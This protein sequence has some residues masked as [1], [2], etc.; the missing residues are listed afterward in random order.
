M[1]FPINEKK[2][3]EDVAEADNIV[4]SI[5]QEVAEVKKEMV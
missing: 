3:N 2:K 4:G 1:A 5:Q